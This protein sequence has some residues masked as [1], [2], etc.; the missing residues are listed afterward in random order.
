MV[1]IRNLREGEN[2][3]HTSFCLS[4]GNTAFMRFFGSIR[5]GTEYLWRDGDLK[6]SVIF[7]FRKSEER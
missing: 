3:I 5:R 1:A 6:A 4:L 7:N 2:P